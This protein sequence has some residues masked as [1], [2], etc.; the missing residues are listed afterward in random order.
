MMCF[1]GCA[2][3]VASNINIQDLNQAQSRRVGPPSRGLRPYP[4]SNPELCI[5]ILPAV[6][7]H[8]QGV[9]MIEFVDTMLAE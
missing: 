1:S 8:A 6:V 5:T 9:M 2:A 3:E 7:S 4:F